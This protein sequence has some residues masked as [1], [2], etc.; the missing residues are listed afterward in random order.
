MMTLWLEEMARA[1]RAQGTHRGQLGSM[2][3]LVRKAGGSAL[4][5]RIRSSHLQ[6]CSY[7]V[8]SVLF[9]IRSSCSLGMMAAISHRKRQYDMLVGTSSGSG[10]S[11]SSWQLMGDR[12]CEYMGLTR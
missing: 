12:D 10:T 9:I 11:S 5:V 1:R 2:G 3:M 7:L 6:T 4:R 8:K